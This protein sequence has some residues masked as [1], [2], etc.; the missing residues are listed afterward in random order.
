MLVSSLQILQIFPAF[1]RVH[2][3][4]LPGELLPQEPQQHVIKKIQRQCEAS[5]SSV[6]PSPH[7]PSVG[8]FELPL[9]T[10][11][12]YK[13]IPGTHHCPW[14]HAHSSCPLCT[15]GK[16]GKP[17]PQ[18]SFQST[19]LARSL[20]QGSVFQAK[21]KDVAPARPC[22]ARPLRLWCELEGLRRPLGCCWRSSL[23]LMNPSK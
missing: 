22:K 17:S 4:V 3:A 5:N 2:M 6:N 20:K 23:W 15:A 8:L 7:W 11:L 10:Y 13:H 21:L 12:W 19:A 18:T 9:C 14:K 16:S 1:P